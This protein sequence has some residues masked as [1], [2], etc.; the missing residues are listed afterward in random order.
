MS[1]RKYYRAIDMWALTAC[2]PTRHRAIRLLQNLTGN[3]QMKMEH[4]DAASFRR[5]DGIQVYKDML[6]KAYEPIEEF[7]IG[8]IMDEFIYRFYRKNDQDIAVFNQAF[9]TEIKRVT[10]AAGE[11]NARWKTH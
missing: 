4:V 2:I 7:R 3:A 5:R 1:R 11:L 6:E 8:R 9:E 10:E